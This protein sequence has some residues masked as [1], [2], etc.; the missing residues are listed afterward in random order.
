MRKFSFNTLHTT[1]PYSGRSPDIIPK[2]RG[3]M[4]N[5]N[6]EYGAN[7]VAIHSLAAW[8]HCTVD[9]C[10]SLSPH[11]TVSA[12]IKLELGSPGGSAPDTQ[13]VPPPPN[14]LPAHV[15][16]PRHALRS[17]VTDWM[18]EFVKVKAM[19][20]PIT[21]PQVGLNP[22]GILQPSV[23]TCITTTATT[24]SVN[25]PLPL[26]SLSTLSTSPPSP[27]PDP[28]PAVNPYAGLSSGGT[29]VPIGG[30]QHTPVIFH[31]T[32]NSVPSSPGSDS[33]PGHPPG[34]GD[35]LLS[36]AQ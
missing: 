32:N 1:G 20:G 9:G 35:E 3:V 27:K 24:S 29:Q 33:P 22:S 17:A 26:S 7:F 31:M 15:Y 34:P 16:H 30:H 2:L 18:G 11:D 25:S 12:D 6:C 13:L 36:L 4:T 14:N 10:G 19:W 5:P 28:L 23:N 8:S 21:K